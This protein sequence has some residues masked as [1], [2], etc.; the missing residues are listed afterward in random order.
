MERLNGAGRDRRGERGPRVLVTG[1]GGPSGYCLLRNLASERLELLA[2]DIDPCAAG[3]YLV[4][5]GARG[6]CCAEATTPA[7]PS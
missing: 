4:P 6:S 1:A 2:G 7:S 3:L 5:D